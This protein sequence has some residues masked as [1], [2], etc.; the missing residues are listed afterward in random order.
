MTSIT[1]LY[2]HVVRRGHR[3][4]LLLLCVCVICFLLGLVMVT[5]VS[6][7]ARCAFILFV[8]GFFV[9]WNN[10]TPPLSLSLPMQG[11]LYVF[12]IYDHFSCSGASLLLLSIFQSVAIGW[13]YGTRPN[14]SYLSSFPPCHLLSFPVLLSFFH[15]FPSLSVPLCLSCLFFSISFHFVSSPPLVNMHRNK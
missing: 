13:I 1:D 12:Q 11:G 9:S 5:P 3:R 7:C 14:S 2:P 8:G 10:V 15:F 4:E 6:G